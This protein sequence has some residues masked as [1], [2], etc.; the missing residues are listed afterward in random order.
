VWDHGPCTRRRPAAVAHDPLCPYP[1]DTPIELRTWTQRIFAWSRRNV[2]NA[3]CRY[4][5]AATRLH[6]P[7][8]AKDLRRSGRRFPC[9]PHSLPRNGETFW[10]TPCRRVLNTQPWLFTPHRD[11]VEL[12]ADKDRQLQ[13]LDPHGRQLLM[14]CG[15]ALLN[16]RH[17]LIAASI[18]TYGCFL[19]MP[20]HC[21]ATVG[22]GKSRAPTANEAA[23][24]RAIPRRRTNR[25]PF[26]PEPRSGEVLTQLRH[27]TEAEG[28]G[29]TVL[30]GALRTQTVAAVRSAEHKLQMDAAAREEVARWIERRSGGEGIARG[31]A[32][33]TIFVRAAAHDD[34]ELGKQL[35]PAVGAEALL[36][37][38]N[39]VFHGLRRDE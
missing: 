27:A 14:S 11:R 20:I 9:V 37:A 15:A 3:L 34:A 17:W 7:R 35:R 29:L 2:D 13:V 6:S 10:R 39:V 16:L 26:S 19:T 36:H 12:H 31:S 18:R 21:T 38:G 5:D 33:E 23:L 8:V 4:G 28:A 1:R 32:S 30:F 24:F 22:L 25:R